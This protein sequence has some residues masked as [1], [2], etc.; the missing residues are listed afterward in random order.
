MSQPPPPPPNQGLNQPYVAPH[1]YDEPPKPKGWS[2]FVIGCLVALGISMVLCAGVGYYAYSQASTWAIRMARTTTETMLRESDLPAEEQSAILEQFDRVATAFK[3][4]DLTFE[5]T[6]ELFTELAE[7][8]LMSVVVFQAMEAKY[9]NSS[10]LTPEEIKDA[11]RTLARLV[12]AA[13][14]EKLE[15]SEIEELSRHILSQPDPSNPNRKQLKNTMTDEELRSFFADATQ[16]LDEKEIPD[17]ETQMERK[18]SDVLREI[19]DR[20]LAE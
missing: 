15:Q 6:G 11:K 19:I 7:S 1:S 9:L 16:L 8:P 13:Q 3:E 2:G 10:G 18:V 17:E 5:E 4:G 14:D 12:R 20:K